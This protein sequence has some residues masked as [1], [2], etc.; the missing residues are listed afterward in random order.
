[1]LVYNFFQLRK[2]VEILIMENNK[3]N[4]SKNCPKR[5]LSAFF[6]FL[7]H[8]KPEITL[9][10]PEFSAKEIVMQVS[11]E[12]KVMPE[13]NK[14]YYTEIAEQKK[15]RYQNELKTMIKYNERK[16]L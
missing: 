2:L 16:N 6:L 15:T 4:S 13:E 7:K 5:P 1:M 3:I 8:R 9:D 12:W 10:N 11:L 14:F